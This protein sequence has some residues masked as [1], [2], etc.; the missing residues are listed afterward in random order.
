ML[1]AFAAV[2]VGASTPI[3]GQAPGCEGDH[4]RETLR[5]M[6]VHAHPDD[7]SSK[8]AATM[9]RY[10]SEGVEV[11]VATCTGGERGS[12]LN[13]KLEHDEWVRDNMAE[14]RRREMAAAREILGVDQAWLGFVVSSSQM[15]L[16][17][18]NSKFVLD[19]SSDGRKP[20]ERV[21]KSA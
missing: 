9:A 4:V 2:S 11:L 19:S 20:M 10:A 15:A 1:A 8:G 5:L 12:I 7:E 18:R 21:R 3:W 16:A 13:P 6:A 17:T 14:V